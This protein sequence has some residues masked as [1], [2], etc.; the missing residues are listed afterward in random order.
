MSSLNQLSICFLIDQQCIISSELRQ[1]LPA[2]EVYDLGK[3]LT[4]SRSYR[5][6]ILQEFLCCWFFSI[7]YVRN[8]FYEYGRNLQHVSYIG[9]G[10]TLHKPGNSRE[11]KFS[12]S[13]ILMW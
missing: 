1:V 4:K 6:Q 13:L 5:G 7:H 3:W 8:C 12:F 11:K 10:S 9:N 2:Y